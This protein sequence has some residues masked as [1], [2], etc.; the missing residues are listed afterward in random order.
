MKAQKTKSNLDEMQEQ[1]LLHIEHNGMWLGYFGLLAAIIIQTV[2]GRANVSQNIA[3]ELILMFCLSLYICIDCLR[4][5]IWDRK[6]KANGKT[7][8]IASILAGLVVGLCVAVT[9]YL[10]YGK[11]A[12]SVAAGLF[13]LI[14]TFVLCFAV[15]S[16][17]AALYRKRVQK[18]EANAEGGEKPIPSI[19]E[20]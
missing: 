17:A 10:H 2:I 19:P 4:N 5:G 11:A 16:L 3:G 20:K 1:K 9:S 12:G 6:L 18:L 13:V 8:L 15:L 7:N 14:G